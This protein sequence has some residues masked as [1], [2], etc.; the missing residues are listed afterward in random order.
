MRGVLTPHRPLGTCPKGAPRLVTM[1]VAYQYKYTIGR[2]AVL[3]LIPFFARASRGW[4][5]WDWRNF[6]PHRLIPRHR[7][8][9][10]EVNVLSQTL[11]SLPQHFF[12][13]GASGEY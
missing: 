10:K 3:D 9:Q 8:D 5:S 6:P 12:K 13:G 4:L 1:M 11:P 2:G 7:T